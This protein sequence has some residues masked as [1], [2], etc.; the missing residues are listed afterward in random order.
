MDSKKIL[1]I[2]L[3]FI[4]SNFY[5]LFKDKY[6]IVVVD[7]F[8]YPC[9]LSNGLWDMENPKVY[10]LNIFEGIQSVLEEEKPDYIVN[11]AA[12]SHVDRSIN[13]NHS[14]LLTNVIGVENILKAMRNTN[15]RLI[16][17]S[18]DEV[19]GDL[20]YSSNY[21]FKEDDVLKPNSPYSASKAAADMIVN[22]YHNTYGTNVVTVR[23]TNN[24]GPYQYPEK[25]IPFIIKRIAENKTIPIYGNGK[26]E[27]EW[28]YVEDCCRAVELV[29]TDGVSGEIYNIGSGIDNRNSNVYI[30]GQLAGSNKNFEYISDRP[31]HDKKYSVNSD[32]IRTL[33]WEPKMNLK[34]G[35]NITKDWY[36]QRLDLIKS[37]EANKHIT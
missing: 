13:E 27:R 31:G 28:L 36:F 18:T 35:L 15:M 16:H 37:M 8:S 4:G 32:K 22:A 34:E 3:G 25:L 24:Y 26:N 7:N 19:Y 29:M 33:G 10:P 11:T 14:F 9:T 2:G 17:F 5:R 6:T 12:D 20:D 1:L 21:E 30:S 23:P